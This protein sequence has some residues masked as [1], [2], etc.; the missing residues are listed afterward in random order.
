MDESVA[1]GDISKEAQSALVC[2]V[3]H[4]V[5]TPRIM[6]GTELVP[7]KISSECMNER[8]STLP[9]NLNVKL[10]SY[11]AISFPINSYWPPS[12]IWHSPW[13]PLLEF[14]THS[15]RASCDRYVS[16]ITTDKYTFSYMSLIYT[17]HEH[18]SLA[19]KIIPH[20]PLSKNFKSHLTYTK[21]KQV[22]SGLFPKEI[23]L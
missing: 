12:P 14:R 1:P 10:L 9:L 20:I 6:W 11:C 13:L 23:A 17:I 22:D 19:I 5:V 16:S 18:G 2:L 7:T 8:M 15:S 3:H 21:E 4:F